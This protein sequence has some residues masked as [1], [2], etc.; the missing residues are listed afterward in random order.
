MLSKVLGSGGRLRGYSALPV[1]AVGTMMPQEV[2]HVPHVA[3]LVTGIRKADS[4]S[5][6]PL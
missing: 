6:P 2:P 1:L 5:T 3:E 4:T